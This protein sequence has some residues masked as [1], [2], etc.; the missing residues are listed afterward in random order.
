M[1][2]IK[3]IEEQKEKLET[4]FKSN[5]EIQKLVQQNTE[6]KKQVGDWITGT[7]E[8]VSDLR[9]SKKKVQKKVKRQKKVRQRTRFCCMKHWKQ[10][11]KKQLLRV[12]K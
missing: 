3:D 11:L 7:E 6:K 4:D 12:Y 1:K 2:L 9:A 10:K 8:I 5:E